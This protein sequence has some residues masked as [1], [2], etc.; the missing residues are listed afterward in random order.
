MMTRRFGNGELSARG[1]VWAE[2]TD[3]AHAEVISQQRRALGAKQWKTH[4]GGEREWHACVGSRFG[5]F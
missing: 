4:G 3:R 5:E 1:A 2:R